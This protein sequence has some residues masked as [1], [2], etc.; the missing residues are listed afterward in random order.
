MLR[1]K[2]NK[3]NHLIWK[4]YLKERHL[5][6]PSRRTINALKWWARLNK[7][8]DF[9][10]TGDWRSHLEYCSDRMSS[11]RAKA[12]LRLLKAEGVK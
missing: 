6:F 10:Y 12:I 9:R 5:P 2:I 8:D 1:G 7:D 4:W 3:H 11:G